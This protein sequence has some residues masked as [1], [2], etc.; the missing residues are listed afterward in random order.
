MLPPGSRR[1]TAILAPNGLGDPNGIHQETRKLQ[2]IQCVINAHFVSI[3]SLIRT[4]AKA[5]Y[6]RN[7]RLEKF[8]PLGRENSDPKIHLTHSES[9]IIVER[10]RKRLIHIADT[11][12]GTIIPGRCRIGK[13]EGRVRAYP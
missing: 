8:N 4:P 12:S 3:V 7:M 5:Q 13:V 9:T 11:Q 1:P 2:T 10:V 6:C